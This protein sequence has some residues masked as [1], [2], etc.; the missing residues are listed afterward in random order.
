MLSGKNKREDLTVQ[1][2]E[3]Y[4]Q[5]PSIMNNKND[6]ILPSKT[7]VGTGVCSKSH[8]HKPIYLGIPIA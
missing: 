1:V 5:I 4:E 8:T 7:Q 2:K 3:D 6:R